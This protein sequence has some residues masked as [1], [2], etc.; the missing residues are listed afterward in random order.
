MKKV[1]T[2][3]FISLSVGVNAQFLKKLKAKVSEKINTVVDQKVDNE[4]D[5]VFDKK[6]TSEN[7]SNTTDLHKATGTCVIKHNNSLGTVNIDKLGIFKV[8]VSSEKIEITGYWETHGIDVADNFYLVIVDEN[9]TNNV[10]Y[11]ASKTYKLYNN[12]D[13]IT[14]RGA[15]LKIAYNPEINNNTPDQYQNYTLKSGSITIQNIHDDVLKFTANGT[16]FDQYQSSKNL[17]TSVNTTVDV[18]NINISY[19]ENTVETK[20][21][22]H[23]EYQNMDLEKYG[24]TKTPTVN[25]TYTFNTQIEFEI[26]DG[27]QT[28]YM[29][30]WE[31]EEDYYAMEMKIDE[32]KAIMITDEN[33][34]LSLLENEGQKTQIPTQNTFQ[35][36]YQTD[37]VEKYQDESTFTKTG[38]T[39]TVLGYQ[40]SEYI[41]NDKDLKVTFWITKE[42][43]LT[44]SPFTNNYGTV[45]ES[46]YN[47]GK[48]KV[49][50]KAT[51]IH[52]KIISINTKEYKNIM[53][54][55]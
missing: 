50:S 42:L 6:E 15:Y 47:Q 31:S 19:H 26:N 36:S 7:T 49:T 33:I 48:E 28:N 1:I 32:G 38:N 25:K 44:N 21:Q 34:S 5:K 24:I 55:F 11:Y 41:T 51:N 22:N 9:A 54:M 45:L 40:C 39:K 16:P 30:I 53:N 18:S 8:I 29:S 35:N 13:D 43:E 12:E 14:T 4:I 23:E 10:D 52:H 37:F 27:N 46:V 2:L 20:Q 3:L 17:A